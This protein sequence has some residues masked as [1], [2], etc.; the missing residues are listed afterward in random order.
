MRLPSNNAFERSLTGGWWRAARVR[1]N[2][3]LAACSMR[4]RAAAQLGR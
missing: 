3:T 1:N 4:H 2:F